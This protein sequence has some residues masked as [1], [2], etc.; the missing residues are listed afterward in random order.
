MCFLSLIVGFDQ[1]GPRTYE[2]M[3]EDG[4]NVSS[5]TVEA[6]Y[7]P[8]PVKLEPRESVNSKWSSF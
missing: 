3:D 2:L 4:K 7:I 6:R 8:V 1:S 5:V